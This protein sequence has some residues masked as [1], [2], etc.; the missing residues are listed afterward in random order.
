MPVPIDLDDHAVLLPY[1]FR[2]PVQGRLEPELVEDGGAEIVGQGTGLGD[3]FRHQGPDGGQVTRKLRI[4]R[5][6]Q[7]RP[8]LDIGERQHL[9]NPVVQRLGD[10]APLPLLALHKFRRQ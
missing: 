7:E 4:R 5:R 1:P 8:D 9:S 3:R 6:L 2:Q 10:P